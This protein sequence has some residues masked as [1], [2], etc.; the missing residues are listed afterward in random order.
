VVR[1][2][3]AGVTGSRFR[4]SNKVR[5]RA[6]IGTGAGKDLQKNGSNLDGMQQLFA[7][8]PGWRAP[9]AVLAHAR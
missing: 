4:M 7:A 3:G 5:H 8:S 1:W 6:G 9:A 2:A